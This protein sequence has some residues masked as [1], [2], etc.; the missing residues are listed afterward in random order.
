MF[1]PIAQS[2]FE[3]TRIT[4]PHSGPLARDWRNTPGDAPATAA[5]TPAP[6]TQGPQKPVCRATDSGS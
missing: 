5:V 6:R 2:I 3:A 1:L 4:P